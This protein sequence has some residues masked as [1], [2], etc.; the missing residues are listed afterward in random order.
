MKITLLTYGTRGDVQ[1][2]VALGLGLQRAGHAA[3]IAAPEVFE[4]FVTGHGLDFYPLPGDPA[5]LSR[6]LV[7]EAQNNRVRMVQVMTRFAIPLAARVMGAARDACR[8]ADTVVHGFLMTLAGHEMARERGIPDFSAQTFPA[9]AP[10]GRTPAL[11][12]AERPL[13]PVYNRLT[14]WLMDQIFFRSSQAAYLAVRRGN[15]DLPR[16]VHWPFG[17]SGGRLPTPVLMAISPHVFPPPSDWPAR[18]HVTGYWFLDDDAG[19]EPP[20]ALLRFLDDGPPPV[21][22]GF[23]SVVTG[24]AGRLGQVALEA[25]A[26]SGLRGVLLGGWAGIA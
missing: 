16:R 14:H 8:E 24:R 11:V 13:G 21:A 2:F 26:R 18:N 3:R 7:D 6:L 22:I 1:P 5:E 15:P 9:F 20:E 10:S 17:R 4:G 23:G 25:L 19:W 12:A